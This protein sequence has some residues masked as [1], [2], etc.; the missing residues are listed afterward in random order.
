MNESLCK[1][2]VH[3]LSNREEADCKEMLFSHVNLW[4]VLLKS[5][6]IND[7][8]SQRHKYLENPTDP[9]ISATKLSDPSY[10]SVSV[11]PT[12]PDFWLDRL[13]TPLTP[14]MPYEGSG[15]NSTRG[16]KRVD[17][18]ENY[19]IIV[20]WIPVILAR[21]ASRDCHPAL[22]N[23]KVI[24]KYFDWRKCSVCHKILSLLPALSLCWIQFLSSQWGLLVL[25]HS[26]YFS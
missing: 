14:S 19:S 17:Y 7:N 24:L 22:L 2:C 12:C 9:P 20:S 23:M 11:R 13:D 6:D 25:S 8:Q 26:E 15:V 5:F 10:L 1:N 21:V 4:E 3:G 16:L 18:W